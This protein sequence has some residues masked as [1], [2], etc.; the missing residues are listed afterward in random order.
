MPKN[1]A[2]PPAASFREPSVPEE[3]DPFGGLPIGLY[4]SAPDGRLLYANAALVEMLGYP[5][6]ETL[7]SAPIEDSYPNPDDRRRWL[8]IIERDGVVRE[9]ENVNRRYDGSLIWIRD[10]GLAVRDADGRTLFYEGVLQ[11][12]TERKL[13]EGQLSRER[14]YFTQLFDS[15]PEG[16]AMVNPDDR[17]IQVNAEF[18]RMFGYSRE[19]AVGR[20]LNDLIVP[21]ELAAE[22]VRYSQAV[23]AGKRLAFESYRVA[24]DGRRIPVSVL[25]HPFQAA[26]EQPAVY[27]IYRDITDIVGARDALE[28]T[29]NRFRS[30]IENASDLVSVFDTSGMRTYVSPSSVRAFGYSEEEMLTTNGFSQVHPD[31]VPGVREAFEWLIQNPNE[32]RTVEFRIRRKDGEWRRLSSMGKNL[33]ADPA[34]R[35]IVINSRDVTEQS[36]LAEQLRKSQRMEAVGRL[37]GGVAHDF[38]NLLT[39]ITTYTDFILGDTRVARAHRDDLA[40]IRRAAERAASLTRQLLAFGRGQVLQPRIL[41][42]NAEVRAAMQML[43][44]VIGGNIEIRADEDRRLWR[45]NADEGQIQQVL[46][47][48][49]LN[50]RDA[51]PDGGHL[52][53]S[54]EN[55]SIGD[56]VTPGG[57]YVMP[58]GD[59]VVL[60]VSDDGI[61]MDTSTQ[62]RVFEPFFTTKGQ[63]LG[64]GLGLATVYGIVKQSGGYIDVRSN[65]GEGT[66]FE[67]SLPRADGQLEDDTTRYAVPPMTRQAT[68]LLAEDE[69]P[70]RNAVERILTSEG[71][72]VLLA[73]NG[74]EALELFTRHSREIDILLTDIVMPEMG[75]IELARE[76]SSWRP[77]L[78][79]L[80]MSGFTDVAVLRTQ[81]L[82]DKASFIE[83]PFHRDALMAKIA[84]LLPESRNVT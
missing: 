36:Q 26:G 45:V 40:E 44:R 67:I 70:V 35:G 11:D 60:M 68:F 55:R 5:D 72:K 49:A 25:S 30:L 33:L 78:R 24:K 82:A 38:N 74:R 58:A 2:I 71:H 28:A 21:P 84:E 34:V 43:E 61:G 76:C 27:V 31:D 50:A 59:Y 80:F 13:A 19:E 7:A 77:S 69:L 4:R 75:G 81:A 3:R 51:M 47:N 37:A 52:T 79:V 56:T 57:E 18:T 29:Q 65:P 15:L 83:K 41:D 53:F 66:C 46:L 54:T 64:T 39:V 20:A 48:L 32:T 12:V 17:V 16:I 42:L 6:L 23:G 63:G 8:E 22:G 14:E 10:S 9:F 1:V 62:R 73:S